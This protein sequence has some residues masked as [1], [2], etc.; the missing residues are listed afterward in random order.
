MQQRTS[1]QN[2][3]RVGCV[4]GMCS[5]HSTLCVLRWPYEEKGKTEFSIPI[6]L[7]A[8]VSKLLFLETLP[9][10]CC[11]LVFQFGRSLIDV[12]AENHD[13]GKLV[14]SWYKT[15]PGFWRLHFTHVVEDTFPITVLRS[16]CS[17]FFK[18][19]AFCH[20]LVCYRLLLHG[21]EFRLLELQLFLLW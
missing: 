1:G 17:P 16:I 15:S 19:A 20:I 14:N 4:Y 3:I 13:T 12:A 21:H 10:I 7:K 2:R 5:N 8:T 18:Q 6:S 11:S 9:G